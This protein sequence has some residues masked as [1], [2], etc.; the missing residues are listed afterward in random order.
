MSVRT[1]PHRQRRRSRCRP[2]RGPAARGTGQ[3]D[4]APAEGARSAAAFRFARI[5]D[6]IRDIRNGKL[7]IVVDDEDRENEG[8]LTMAAEKVTAAA[9]NFMAAH[10]RGLICMPIVGERLDQLKIPAMVSENTSAFETA[11][12]VSVEAKREVSTGISAHDRAV[13]IKTILDPNT[14]PEDLARP[15]H[16]FPLRAREGGVLTRAGQTEAAV[17]LARLAG[18]YP[19]GRDLRDHEPGRQHGPRAG[20]APLRP[21]PRPP[22]DHHQGPDRLP[23]EA[24]EVRDPRGHHRPADPPRHLPDDPV[25]QPGGSEAP[26]GPD[27]GRGA[28]R[29]ADAGPRPLRVPDRRRARLAP[30]RLRRAAR[31]RPGADRRRG[32]RRS[33]LHPAGGPRHRARQQAPG[34]R[35][36][37][38]GL[39]HGGGER[40]ARLQARPAGLRRRRPDPRGP[41]HLQAPPHDQQPAEDR[42]PGGVRPGGRGAGPPG[43]PADG[44]ES[45]LPHHEAREAGAP[46]PARAGAS[47]APPGRGRDGPCR[48]EKTER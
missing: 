28:A 23:H 11:F 29:R 13:T 43:H 30:L 27:Q 20:T 37:G 46:H 18:L 36:A 38:P 12:A 35:A 5:E 8:D 26:P 1:T 22:D 39:R 42:G 34:L 24:G 47:Q 48:P 14:R 40:A 25:P 3:E 17:D 33:P 15:G 41:G 32:A 10:G 16:T 4:R 44:H 9:I 6:A 45:G 21:A 19:A 31:P 2:T 7:V